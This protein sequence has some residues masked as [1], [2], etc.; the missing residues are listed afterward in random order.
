MAEVSAPPAGGP[1]P[2]IHHHE[3][4][5]FYVREGTLA[6]RL[7]DRT[8]NAAPGDFVFTSL[9]EPCIPSRTQERVCEDVR[10][11]HTSRDGQV[12]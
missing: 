5:S 9:E 12:F 3:D 1:P 6:I 8:L 2:H 10:D 7:G 4:E 11:V